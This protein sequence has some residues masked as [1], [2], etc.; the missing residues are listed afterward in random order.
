MAVSMRVNK[1]QSTHS[2]ADHL[3]RL[4][5]QISSRSYTI[6]IAGLG[7]VGLP[8][9]TAIDT[10]NVMARAGITGANVAKA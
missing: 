5:G 8:Q 3:A 9:A 2:G 1:L 7:Y 6:G 4:L 10:S